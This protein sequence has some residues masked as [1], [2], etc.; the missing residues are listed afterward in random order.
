MGFLQPFYDFF[1]P[2]A[3][4][5]YQPGLFRFKVVMAIAVFSIIITGWALLQPS[6]FVNN[7][8]TPAAVIA[9]V[10]AQLTNTDRAQN[11]APP[12]TVNPVLAT[13]AQMKAD[14]M[15]ARGYFSHIGPD[16]GLPWDF[17]RKVGYVYRY[18]GENLAVNFFDSEAVAQAWMNSPAHRANMVNPHFTEVGFGIAE[19][20]YQGKPSVF[21]VEFF[22]SPAK[23]NV[24]AASS[25]VTSI[26]VAATTTG[27]TSPKAA[28]APR[29]N[30]PLASAV[31]G[32]STK[33]LP[34][35]T[36]HAAVATGTMAVLGT[37][38]A[39]L[40]AATTS[41]ATTSLLASA[42][43]ST[44]SS[45][46]L[47]QPTDGRV[48]GITIDESLPPPPTFWQK[49]LA[50][51]GSTSAFLI[52]FLLAI[53]AVSLFLLWCSIFFNRSNKQG[54]FFL[55]NGLGLA[56]LLGGLLWCNSASFEQS[57]VLPDQQAAAASAVT[58]TTEA[59]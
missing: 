4:N 43:T 56:A 13:A 55:I 16:G 7:S 36:I 50:S 48:L 42:A 17:F 11:A 19:G 30:V 2:H 14:D 1:V 21:V 54:V 37:S 29:A 49:L 59:P 53:V 40:A 26:A 47:G 51:P 5:R 38:T 20:T 57:I 15:V 31:A 58:W 46:A 12:L 25:A 8:Q 39:A 28:A 44:T 6:R 9:A 10:L 27:T 52:Q 33:A 35:T 45:T 24:A 22:G 32:T 3:G 23:G 34:R 41:T 18:A